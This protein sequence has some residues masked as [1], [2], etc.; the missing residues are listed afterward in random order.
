M[1][2]HT[3]SHTAHLFPHKL[4]HIPPYVHYTRC[5]IWIS[6]K[7]RSE[8]NTHKQVVCR[9]LCENA[10]TIRE[11]PSWRGRA[12]KTITSKKHQQSSDENANEQRA[13]TFINTFR[14]STTED[15]KVL[16]HFRRFSPP[17]I[18]FGAAPDTETP[19]H[20]ARSLEKGR[21]TS[22]DRRYKLDTLGD[23]HDNYFC[24]RNEKIINHNRREKKRP[25]R[26]VKSATLQ[27]S[28]FCLPVTFWR[29][30]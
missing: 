1:L 29:G 10:R 15:T 6:N 20:S 25:T 8:K 17:T 23:C 9:H 24:T 18:H 27:K 3:A 22:P 4:F 7:F 26:R 16:L 13:L 30:E 28:V 11:K 5:V 19:C 14:V 21:E 12:V 2:I